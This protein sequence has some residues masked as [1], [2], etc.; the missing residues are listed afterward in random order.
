MGMFWL[1]ILWVGTWVIVMNVNDIMS[2][3]YAAFWNIAWVLVVLT[4]FKV[5]RLLIKLIF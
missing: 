5:P 3:G 1:A 2:Q 4:L